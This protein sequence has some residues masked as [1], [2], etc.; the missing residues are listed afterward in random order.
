[1]TSSVARLIGSSKALLKAKL[2]PKKV[3]GHCQSD[4]LQLSEFWRN[5]YVWEV[6]AANQKDRHFEMLSSHNLHSN[7]EPFL[8]WMCRV[9]KSEFYT[10]TDKN[11]LSSWTLKKL[12]STS[13]SQTCTTK[14]KKRS[15]SLSGCLLL[16][17][18]TT[19]FWILAKPLHLRNTLSKSLRCTESCNPWS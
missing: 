12:Q 3:H 8:D 2:V 18:S 5:H 11:Q 9:T 10:T 6:Y 7:N 14:K 16:V 15:W 4:P 17:W 1:M 13:Q 19:A